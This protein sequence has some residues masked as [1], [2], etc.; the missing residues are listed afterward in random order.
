VKVR[1][2]AEARQDLI[3]IGDYIARD[4]P[5]RALSFVKELA[6]TCANL[7]AMPRAWP[8]LPR[9]EAQAIRRRVHG[10]YQVFYRIDAEHISIIRILHGARDFEA[11]L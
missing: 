11:L 4:N 9:Y 1:L 3:A 5:A 2:S 6:E 7:A 8:I 10:N